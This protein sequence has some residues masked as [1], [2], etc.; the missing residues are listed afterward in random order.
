MK[1]VID[2]V[3]ELKGDLGNLFMG[4]DNHGTHI[5]WRISDKGHPQKFL[6]LSDEGG[7][8]EFIQIC[9]IEEFNAMVAEMSE[10]F[11]E[12]KREY[13]IAKKVDVA[14]YNG[15]SYALNTM[16]ETQDGVK[17]VLDDVV[18]RVGLRVSKLCDES[19]FWIEQELFETEIILGTITPAPVEFVDGK[20]Y[21]FSYKGYDGL[22]A[23][24]DEQSLALYTQRMSWGVRDCTNIIPLVPEVK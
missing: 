11:E 17:V 13:E 19:N 20:A 14:T 6:S 16:Y 18:D 8:S 7:D 1:T 21:M 10:G 23:L 24:Y 15:N 22:V 5:Y 2:A 12:Y 9:T 4:Q 3:N